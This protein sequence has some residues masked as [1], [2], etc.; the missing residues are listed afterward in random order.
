MADSEI[1]K[2]LRYSRDDEWTRSDGEQVVIG[3]T[4]YAQT[5]LGD[6]VFLELPEVGATITQGEVFGTIESVKAVSD[7]FAPLTGEVVAVNDDLANQPE[8][9]NDA[10]Y[11]A[12]WLLE[13]HPEDPDQLEGLLDAD[14][15]AAHCDE[16]S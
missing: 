5:Q 11:T 1:P 8:L 2:E 14:A 4:D 9:V 15:Y 10:P 13:V 16:R 12:G 7:L 6:I 3:V